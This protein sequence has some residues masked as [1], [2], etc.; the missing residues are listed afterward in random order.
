MAQRWKTF[1]ANSTLSASDVN[2]VLNPSTADHI[3]RAVAAGKIGV[4]ATANSV[5]NVTINFPAGRFTTP[6][7]VVA[8]FQSSSN[9][10][11]GNMSVLVNGV[12][13]T[14]ASLR[15]NNASSTGFSSLDV[16]WIAVQM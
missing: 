11:I 15:I 4:P 1:T 6:P 2:D 13:T 10:V 8:C 9:V 7:L 3:F 16:A 14:S 5:G 12:T